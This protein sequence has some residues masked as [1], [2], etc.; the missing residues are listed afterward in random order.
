[1]LSS[2]SLCGW[3]TLVSSMNC[4]DSVNKLI[5]IAWIILN[6]SYLTEQICQLNDWA[7]VASLQ[8][9]FKITL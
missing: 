3:L 1:M 4:A 2:S 8:E 5:V 6:K 9:T 7:F